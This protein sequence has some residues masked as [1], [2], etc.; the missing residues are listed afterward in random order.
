MIESN[1]RHCGF[2]CK[3]PMI[4]CL[5]L[6]PY[7]GVN[8]ENCRCDENFSSRRNI[9]TNKKSFNSESLMK[10]REHLSENHLGNSWWRLE[11]WQIGRSKYS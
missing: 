2:D 6:C 5:C 8:G 10:S 1:C 9:S 4:Y 3:S 11:K 7:C